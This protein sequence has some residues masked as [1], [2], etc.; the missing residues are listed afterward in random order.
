MADNS[1]DSRMAN[2][3]NSSESVTT[4][5][6]PSCPYGTGS[7]RS[8]P[9]SVTTPTVSNGTDESM[10]NRSPGRRV[11]DASAS[12]M[13]VAC[14]SA[15]TCPSRHSTEVSNGPPSALAR[16]STT[17]RALAMVT[18]NTS[19]SRGGTAV[20][21]ASQAVAS[22]RPARSRRTM[23]TVS[24]SCSRSSRIHRS[25]SGSTT[26]FM[27]VFDHRTMS[28]GS[29]RCHSDRRGD[30]TGGGASLTA[31]GDR[32]LSAARARIHSR[33]STRSLAWYGSTSLINGWSCGGP[34]TVKRP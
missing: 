15:R 6:Q 33:P 16:R 23:P 21:R 22:G 14:Q 13:T 30:S 19:Q 12:P 4:A 32:S 25:S 2:L 18:G 29:G 34:T 24:T 28:Q 20:I 10:T 7:S 8:L 11:R 17:L 3:R 5:T 1:S 9:S 31:K 26:R 27:E